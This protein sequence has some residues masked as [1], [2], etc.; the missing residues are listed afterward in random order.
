MN[1]KMF[2]VTVW[3][4]VFGGSVWRVSAQAEQVGAPVQVVWELVKNTSADAPRF[5]ARLVVKNTSENVLPGSGWRLYF[6]LRYHGHDLRSLS[7]GAEIRQVSGEF[8]YVAPSS[9][10]KPVARGESFTVDFSGKAPVANYQDVPSGFF[11]T[12]D[13][14]S[15]RAIV[16]PNPTVGRRDNL[17]AADY[18]TAY[19]QNKM[20]RDIPLAELPAIFPT[21]AAYV[22]KGGTL[23]LTHDVHITADPVFQSEADFLQEEMR[24][25][26]NTPSPSQASA[27]TKTISFKKEALPAEAYRL[28]ITPQGITIA[29]SDGAGAFYGM[30]SLQSLFPTD[31]A[32][33]NAKSL[34]LPC[35]E[36]KD[37]PRFPIRAFMLDVARNFQSKEQVLRILDVMSLYKLNVFHFH[38]SDDEGWRLEI[39]GLP[40]LTETGSVRGYPFQNN[41]RLHPSYGSGSTPGTP[42]GSGHYSRKD[43]LEILQYATLRH[44]QVIPEIESPGHARAAIHSMDARYQ[45]YMQENNRAEAER[46][47]L[48]DVNDRSVYR[49][50]QY[51]NDNVM[52]VA[53]PST[54]AF[55]DKVVTEIQRM[56]EE[57]NAPLTMIHMA[58]DEVPAG[59]WE[60]S[61][62]VAAYMKQNPSLKTSTDLWRHYFV[63]MK[64]ILTAHHLMLYGWEELVTGVQKRDDS[65]EVLDIPD[66]K[67]GNVLIDAWWNAGGHEA[68]PYQIANKGY[69]VVL[70]CVDHFYFDMAHAPSF[71]EPGDAWVGF[72]DLQKTYSFIPFDYYRNTATS[73]AGAPL[74]KDYFNGKEKLNAAGKQHIKGLQGALWA[75]NLAR[76]EL[77]EYMLLPRLLALAERAWAPEADWEREPDPA[78]SLALYKTQ[79]SVFMNVLGKKEL[80][81][82]DVYQGGY[83]YHIPYPGATVE[84]GSIAL[85]LEVPGFDIRYTTDGSEPTMNSLRYETPIKTKGAVKA[86]AFNQKGRSSVTVVIANP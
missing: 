50:N 3:L 53:L 40:E 24:A 21:P 38:F 19:D 32:P 20:V 63:R 14:D 59:S 11:L 56:Y 52:N 41:Q 58:G 60:K 64:E 65:R 79:W 16:V 35:A 12:W 10:F 75:E 36:I 23:T 1:K 15:A 61:P 47:L 82:L 62:A 68:M 30:R 17:P 8:F 71:E 46:Y 43:F 78:K 42:Q 26:F 37:Q 83:A 49:S 76:Q 81:K 70:A 45:K 34:T 7:P 9:S 67:N 66:F 72:I 27:Q 18:R 33:A 54:Y 80:P 5:Q 28:S 13:A 73:L 86:K 44:I 4:A 84:K 85:N 2:L 57:V 31:I 29:A 22:A 6:N 51:F 25:L 39:P 55:I 74:P 48:R 77:V 69:D